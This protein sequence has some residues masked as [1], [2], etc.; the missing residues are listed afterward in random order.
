[1]EQMTNHK[2]ETL[3]LK[4][5]NSGQNMDFFIQKGEVDGEEEYYF[6]LC[7]NYRGEEDMQVDFDCLTPDQFREFISKCYKLLKEN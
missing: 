7:G 3:S 4:A 1:M 2:E 6:T 5:V